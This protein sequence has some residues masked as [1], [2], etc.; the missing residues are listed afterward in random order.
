MMINRINLKKLLPYIEEGA[1]LLTPNLRIRD[2]IVCQYLNE[3]KTGV[4]PTP[5]VYP[6]DVFIQDH[7]KIHARRSAES[8]SNLSLI[9]SQEELLIW[10]HVLETCLLSES[11]LNTEETANTIAHSYRMGKQ[12]LDN[13]IFNQEVTKKSDIKDVAVF[14]EWIELFR[15]YCNQHRVI[16][17]VDATQILTEVIL[18]NGLETSLK[19]IVLVNFFN[20]PP[21]YRKLF[22]ALPNLKE[23][24]TNTID[25]EMKS[26]VA[27]KTKLTF[28]SQDSESNHC[29]LWVKKILTKKPNAHI[30]IL[31][32]DK[33]NSREKLELALKDALTP[34][35]FF[36]NVIHESLFNT[37]GNTENLLDSG[38]I[39][40]AFLILNL[41]ADQ[42]NT[43]DIIRLLQSPFINLDHAE[44]SDAE[45]EDCILLA[46]SLKQ[47]T[48]PIISSRELFYLIK[49]E[50]TSSE[51]AAILVSIRTEIRK[52]NLQS[53]PL[54]WRSV[55]TKA[56]ESFGWP[57][58]IQSSIEYSQHE[59]WLNLLN[60]FD[61]SAA[62]LSKLNYS[63]A[64]KRLTLLAKRTLQRNLFNSSLQIS[65]FSLDE[66]VGLEFDYL[67]MLGIDD[68]HWPEPANP[69]PFLPY[70][71]QKQYKIPGSHSEIQL[72]SASTT[73]EILLSSTAV[74]A[75]ASYY[76]SDGE[77][78]FR[79]SNFLQTFRSEIRDNET[80]R[81]LGNEIL[82]QVGSIPIERTFNKDH[83]VAPE[84]L[85]K[86]GSAIISHQSS[87]P[88][89]AFAMNRLNLNP[90]SFNEGGIS[91]IAKGNA[92]HIALEQLFTKILSNKELHSISDEQLATH[93]DNSATKAVEFLIQAHGDLL[94]P[95]IQK[96]EH[97]R[98]AI[99][100]EEFSK[101]EK[102][103]SDF[104]VIDQERSLSVDFGNLT[105]RVRVDRIDRLQ[106]GDIALIDYK[107]GKQTISPKKWHDERPE[108][109]QLPLYYYIADSN[110]LGS[111]S[112]LV[113]ASINSE[114]LGYSGITSTDHFSKQVKPLRNG[115]DANSAW[116]EL[117]T[118]WKEN[119]NSLA[120]EFK[121]GVCHVAP[122]N[123]LTTCN[124]CGLQSICRIQELTTAE[125]NPSK[126]DDL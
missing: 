36:P 124:Y 69:S 111:I 38:L 121:Q 21:L 25:N 120:L 114:K 108:D 6:V 98:I 113:I 86:G 47:R 43:V 39:Y 14:S 107:T 94:T 59:Q 46:G 66:A 80:S 3:T 29:A 119:I 95:K 67:W 101:V 19:R 27:L 30:G 32:A 91:K 35:N 74:E 55:F 42:Y 5:E 92:C 13:E 100:L 75:R 87:C 81:P 48:G 77:Q 16:N 83:P 23:V 123:P 8:N 9:S 37:S 63:S 50:S 65:Y 72:N 57:G 96:I 10:D 88:F 90:E 82:S 109:M 12:W 84:E 2:A 71:L 102:Q 70:K 56:L 125:Q 1:I 7:W 53:A 24:F 22:T 18:K 73:F 126:E 62:S 68:Q 28:Q 106:S 104:E 115:S 97:R 116:Q 85:I 31:A 11:L 41:G 26:Q 76:L 78:E 110:H 17:L 58:K 112:T 54:Q 79:P 118:N 34:L 40:D 51:L 44:E 52:A 117:T 4:A 33:P 49:T 93:I 15:K 105:L 61:S 60:T 89:K 103:R 45:K 99:L 122:V 20:P 64:L